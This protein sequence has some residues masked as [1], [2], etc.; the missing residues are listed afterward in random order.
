M[1]IT[2]LAR[3]GLAVY[4]GHYDPHRNEACFDIRDGEEVAITVEYP[5]APTTPSVAVSGV[6]ASA[7]AISGAKVTLT[8]SDIQDCGYA[9]LTSVVGGVDRT[10]RIRAGS[11]KSQDR[12]DTCGC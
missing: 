6:T 3:G 2:V 7:P 11:P 1:R 12:Y 4:G 8:L 5:S 9:D 10:I